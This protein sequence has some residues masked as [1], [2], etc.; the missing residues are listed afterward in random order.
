[1]VTTPAPVH[2]GAATGILVSRGRRSF[3]VWMAAL[4]RPTWPLARVEHPG[5]QPQSRLSLL[6]RR[7][8]EEQH[9]TKRPE[10]QTAEELR[11][12]KISPLI[13]FPSPFIFST[14]DRPPST[15]FFPSTKNE[16][17]C[18]EHLLE[19]PKIK[20]ERISVVHFFIG[21]KLSRLFGVGGRL[22]TQIWRHIRRVTSRWRE[23]IGRPENC[24]EATAWLRPITIR[25]YYF[26]ELIEERN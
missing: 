2:L 26:L 18:P 4:V 23:V 3:R 6:D 8:R 5:F 7:Y 10:S 16:R 22:A 15:A 1:M 20:R 9:E 21:G 14:S 25:E 12:R 19:L 11:H 24:S 13:F 17:S